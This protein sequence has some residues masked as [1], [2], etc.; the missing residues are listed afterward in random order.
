VVAPLDGVVI[1]RYADTG[2]L[3]QWGIGSNKQ[4]LPIVKVAHPSVPRL[5]IGAGS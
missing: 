4:D 1:W 2:A 5:G 3:I